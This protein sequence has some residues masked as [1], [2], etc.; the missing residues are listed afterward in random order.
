MRPVVQ[1]IQWPVCEKRR[2]VRES[3]CR[4]GLAITRRQEAARCTFHGARVSRASDPGSDARMSPPERIAVQYEVERGDAF[5]SIAPEDLL[6]LSF[7]HAPDQIARMPR[8]GLRT[9]QDMA[10]ELV[11]DRGPPRRCCFA[12]VL[13]AQTKRSGREHVNRLAR[14]PPCAAELR[15]IGRRVAEEYV[16]ALASRHGGPP[17]QAGDVHSPRS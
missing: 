7:D 17:A 14:L 10:G 13:V 6:R 16:G 8:G 5:A 12:V 2:S 9:A 3:R 15:R 11:A 4:I 1:R